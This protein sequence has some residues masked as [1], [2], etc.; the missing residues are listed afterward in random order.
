MLIVPLQGILARQR[1][2]I[3]LRCLQYLMQQKRAAAAAAA[4]CG[5]PTFQ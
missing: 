2:T 3:V 5:H 4:A 1:Y